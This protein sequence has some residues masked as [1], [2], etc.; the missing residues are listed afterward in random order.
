MIKIEF[1]VNG[2]RVDK[3]GLE[4]AME[5]VMFK[6][7]AEQIQAA[8]SHCRCP[9]HGSLPSVIIRARPD[10]ELEVDVEGCCEELERT[11]TERVEQ[12]RE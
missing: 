1:E 11:A 5:G 3:D 2:R 6:A 12:I 7:V 9:K 10:S 8:L 4:P